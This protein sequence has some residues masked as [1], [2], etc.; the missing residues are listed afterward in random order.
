MRTVELP[1][2][3]GGTLQADSFRIATYPKN[4][5]AQLGG[6]GKNP[7]TGG[8]RF[9]VT[10]EQCSA[11]VLDTICE[12]PS[13]MLTYSDDL[14]ATWSDPQTLSQGGVNYFPTISADPT[15]GQVAVAWFTNRYDPFD[16]RQDIELVSFGADQL[17]TKHVQRLTPVSND[18]DADP[19]LH[20]AFIGDY[21]EV[22]AYDR[23]AW[24]H[25]NAN[26]RDVPLLG[27]G[28]PVNQQDN[29][30][31]RTGL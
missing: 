21:I 27:D 4:A 8:T 16:N 23:T 5:V 29:F 10:W 14:G 12:E 19:I 7:G 20:G 15:S 18:P 17:D 11:R 2:P 26:Y 13:V 1:A 25:Y 28:V 31:L 22:F 6:K 24:V 30:L 9:F 3:F